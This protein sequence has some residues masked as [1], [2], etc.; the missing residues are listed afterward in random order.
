MLTEL[1]KDLISKTSDYS[2]EKVK[3]F[4]SGHDWWHTWRV[5]QTANH[6]AIIENADIFICAMAALLHDVSD[7][8]FSSPVCFTEQFETKEFLESLGLTPSVINSILYITENL[9]YSTGIEYSFRKTIEFAVVQDA[10]RLD[11]IGAI[12]I[13]RAFNY[14]GYKNR[15]IF[16][17][18]SI[19]E[20]YA[21]ANEYR[22]SESSSIMHFYEKL[23][24]L[25]EALN[26]PAAK[27]IAEER[28]AFLIE[29]LERFLKEWNEFQE[30]I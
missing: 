24:K 25:K 10:D 18:E 26:T 27:K 6:L 7:H 4:E 30:L 19:P 29:Y 20:V 2:K 28:H 16:L 3:N 11:A 9:S 14:G 5:M 23:L 17:P 8:K 15:P 21:T 13:A 22:N 12:G 1:E